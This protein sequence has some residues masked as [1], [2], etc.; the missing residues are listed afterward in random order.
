MLS[1]NSSDTYTYGEIFQ[2]PEMWKRTY[3]RIFNKRKEIS[4]FLSTYN[5]D[6][7]TII[8]TGAGTSSFI[9]NILT[10]VLPKYNI[11]NIKSI[12]TT[13]ITTHPNTFFQKN[14][15][16]ILVSFA[17]SGNSPESIAVVNLADSIC[18][19]DIAHIFI[20][21]NATGK[22]AER[23]KKENILSLVL[24]PET[25]DKGLAMTSSFTSMLLASMLIFNIDNIEDKKADI[26]ILSEKAQSML[27][28]YTAKIQEIA[29]YEFE[30]VVFLG[31]GEKKGIAE[32]CH[33]KLQEL[34]NGKVI[35]LFDSFLGFRHGPK[36]AL[37]EK[38]LLVYLF[39]DDEKVF[40]YE[41]DLVI[42]INQQMKPVAQTYVAQKK[43]QIMNIEFDMGMFP[44]NYTQTEFDAI[45]YVL[46]GQMFGLFKSIKLNLNPDNPSTDG[47]I[48]RVVEGVTIY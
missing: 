30:R 19:G 31:S 3:Q 36:A 39:S 24:P 8:F 29:S 7:V 1:I 34:T 33:L 23:A 37:N 9:G 27:I 47:K 14:K 12:P 38:T 25:N 41:K 35:C 44:K 11:Y 28:D 26:E 40:Q 48:S 20:T 18:E 46:I 10:S 4:S 16:Y 6:G 13:D 5:N 17:R 22:L 21:C 32:E 45:L 42:Q 15:K 43:Q 2:Q